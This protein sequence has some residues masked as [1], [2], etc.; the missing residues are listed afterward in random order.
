MAA[1][2]PVAVSDIAVLKEVC[3]DAAIYFNPRDPSDIASKLL[4]L[5]T[6]VGLRDEMRVRGL[7]R[8]R[9]FRWDVCVRRNCDLI[10]D[11][12]STN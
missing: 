7:D 9:Q 11:M 12:I 4:E 2:C 8:A 5:A 6:D 1:R 3:G 10:R